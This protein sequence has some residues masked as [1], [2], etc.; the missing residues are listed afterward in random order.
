MRITKSQLRQIIKEEVDKELNEK[1]L[2]IKQIASLGKAGLAPYG[3]R[4]GK[5]GNFYDKKTNEPLDNAEVERRLKQSDDRNLANLARVKAG[6]EPI[7]FRRSAKL[8]KALGPRYDRMVKKFG[9][10]EAERRMDKL[11]TQIGSDEI[12]PSAVRGK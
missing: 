3:V 11:L 4:M 5:D 9:K 1:S 6:E 8:K 12:Q 7:D 2:S 10:E